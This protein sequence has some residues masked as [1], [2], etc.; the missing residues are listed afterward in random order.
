[1]KDGTL[2][3]V[4][5]RGGEAIFEEF[6]ANLRPELEV[7]RVVPV[8]I[9]S[10]QAVAEVRRL[11]KGQ[12]ADMVFIDGDHGYEAVMRDLEVWLPLLGGVGL[13]CGHDYGV[14]EGVARAVDERLPQRSVVS[15]GTIWFSEGASERGY[16]FGG[17]PH[18]RPGPEVR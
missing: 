1:M 13:L 6:K 10:Q 17:D 18:D 14:W 16:V 8:R 5:A 4:K 2:V 11:L 3:E 9:E 12:P 7:G 15:G